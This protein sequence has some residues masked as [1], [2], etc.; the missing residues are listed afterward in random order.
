LALVQFGAF[1]CTGNL[2]KKESQKR[3]HSEMPKAVQE[4]IEVFNG[5]VKAEINKEK[6]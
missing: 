6:G 3:Q 5:K 4:I 1:N 2:L